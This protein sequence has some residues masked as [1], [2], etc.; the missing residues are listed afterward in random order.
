MSDLK[1]TINV[2][3][4]QQTNRFLNLRLPEDIILVN[5]RK[6]EENHFERSKNLETLQ[7]VTVF[8]GVLKKIECV[9]VGGE[10]RV[11]NVVFCVT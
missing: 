3:Q 5:F 7:G 10:G 11:G 8:N 4:I 1:S 2:S 9:T 6:T